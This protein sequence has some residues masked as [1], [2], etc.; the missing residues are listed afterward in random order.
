M[1]LT[2][3]EMQRIADR[4][5][6]I[7]H[8]AKN[9]ITYIVMG[10]KG[11][12]DHLLY[13]SINVDEIKERQMRVIPTF[14]WDYLAYYPG[15]E[16][17][18]L[19]KI[20]WHFQYKLA[21]KNSSE[22]NLDTELMSRILL[23]HSVVSY[24]E[25]GTENGTTWTILSPKPNYPREVLVIGPIPLFNWMPFKL[26]AGVTLLSVFVLSLGVYGLLVPMQRKLRRS[27]M[28]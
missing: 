6:V 7:R 16:K 12:P 1:D 28:L 27:I 4:K 11:D 23:G 15:E 24:N 22:L 13:M 21:I 2:R 18:E 26:A 10:I 8:D 19:A 20:Q 9:Q 25:S 14:I 3:S 17:E 5:A